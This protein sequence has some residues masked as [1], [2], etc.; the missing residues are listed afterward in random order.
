MLRRTLAVKSTFALAQGFATKQAMMFHTARSMMMNTEKLDV[1]VLL[2]EQKEKQKLKELEKKLQREHA[3]KIKQ[4][5][6]KSKEALDLI[7]QKQ[8]DKEKEKSTRKKKDVNSPKRALTPLLW[9]TTRNF[10]LIQGELI[11]NGTIKPDTPSKFTLVQGELKK[12]WDSLAEA[13]KNIYVDLAAQDKLRYQKEMKAY[14][15]KKEANKRPMT[16]YMRFFMEIRPQLIQ[17]NPTAKVTEITKLAAQRWKELSATKKK[18]Y[19]EA[20][21]ADMEVYRSARE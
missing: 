21:E 4:Q 17:E 8:A 18:V 12:R 14:N 16:S 5:K 19:Q 15:K 7:K 13:E 2:K 6:Q 9:F 20:F 1:N 11:S 3:Q 10:A